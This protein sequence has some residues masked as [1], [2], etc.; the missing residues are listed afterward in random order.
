MTVC[1]VN[2]KVINRSLQ[3][4]MSQHSGHRVLCICTLRSICCVVCHRRLSIAS[5][6]DV[7]HQL[8]ASV[9]KYSN[10]WF[11]LSSAIF[12]III[13]QESSA[14]CVF[15]HHC[16]QSLGQLSLRCLQR[17]ANDCNENCFR[18]R[19]QGRSSTRKQQRNVLVMLSHNRYRM[20]PMQLS[21]LQ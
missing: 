3:S 10:N 18:T 2:V 21:L 12:V 19:K 1:T 13:V 16:T 17:P 14:L 4:P 8:C 15:T 7:D 9:A 20:R 6:C 11:K 5:E